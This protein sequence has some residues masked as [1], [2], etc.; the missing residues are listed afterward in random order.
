MVTNHF[1]NGMILQVG[2]TPSPPMP[3]HAPG[4][5]QPYEWI[6]NHYCPFIPPKKQ[7]WQWKGTIFNRR[8]IFIH[9]CFL[10]VMFVFRGVIPLRRRII[11]GGKRAIGDGKMSEPPRLLPARYLHKGRV[12]LVQ[13]QHLGRACQNERK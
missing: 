11:S 2:A 6:M 13:H 8:Y 10:I 5:S 7:T 1:L 9:G 3:T 12:V 4:N